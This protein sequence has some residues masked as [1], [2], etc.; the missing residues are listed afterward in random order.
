MAVDLS[1]MCPLR[2]LFSELYKDAQMVG[3]AQAMVM[4]VMPLRG[5]VAY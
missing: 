1:T 2:I 4:T 5:P 3:M